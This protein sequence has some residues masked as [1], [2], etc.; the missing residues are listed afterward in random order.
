MQLIKF[1]FVVLVTATSMQ[2]PRT[3]VL[4][5]LLAVVWVAALSWKIRPC[6]NTS[7]ERMQFIMYCWMQVLMLAVVLLSVAGLNVS[8]FAAVVL[9][10]VLLM[11]VVVCLTLVGLVWSCWMGLRA[12]A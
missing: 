3:Q 2:E 1:G 10:L 11:V 7:M 12:L 4:V 9:V 8:A 6:S 5:L